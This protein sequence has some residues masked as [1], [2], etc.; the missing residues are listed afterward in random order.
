MYK[1]SS[2]YKP[3]VAA[4]AIA[5][6]LAATPASAELVLLT[7]VQLSGQGIGSTLTALTL[8]QKNGS[9]TESGG[10]NFN[11]STFGDAKTGAS[12]STTFTFAD[13]GI[14]SASQLGLIV[15]LTENDD[16]VTTASPYSITLTAY[17]A[18][19][20]LFQAHTTDIGQVLVEQG[21]GV[22]G[23][24]LVFGL[25]ATEQA[26]LDAFTTA[27]GGLEVFA[28]SAT[29]AGAQGGNDVIQVAQLRGRPRALNVGYANPRFCWRWLHG[30]PPQGPR[31]V[32]AR[33][34][35]LSTTR[36]KAAERR[37]FPSPG[38]PRFFL[39]NEFCA[40]RK[41]ISHDG[42][43]FRAGRPVPEPCT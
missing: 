15:N 39:E 35:F 8:Q 1:F 20:S 6:G 4:A 37:P 11:G 43:T 12:Q 26:Q 34:T 16:T 27:N 30:L 10:V 18:N 13:L 19:G 24:G 25:D 42:T 17:S 9:T 21:G 33:I 41:P 22:G 14:S 7:G 31:P 28:L 40:E 23:S 36:K 29:F 3:I 2:R 5:A 38:R 32:P